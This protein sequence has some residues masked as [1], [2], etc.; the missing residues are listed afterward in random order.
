MTTTNEKP[1]NEA[2][3]EEFQN[4]IKTSRAKTTIKKQ[5]NIIKN[6]LKFINPE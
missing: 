2:L 1:T 3:L 4:K 6:F 5:V